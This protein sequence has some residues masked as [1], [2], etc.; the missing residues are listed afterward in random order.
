MN[1][2]TKHKNCLI[3]AVGKN[4]LH[5]L[6]KKGICNYDI[7]LIVY[8]ESLDNFRADADFICHIKGYKLKAIYK[9]LEWHPYFLDAYD[10]F[11]FPDD[12]I[13]MDVTTINSLFDT[14]HHYRL[15]IAQPSLTMS[16]PT[17]PHLLK[18]KY[19]KL[20]Y[21][22][23][24]EMMVPL[25]SKEALRAVLFTFNENETGWGTEV[26]W[27]LLIKATHQDIAVIHETSVV[28]TRPIQSGQKIHFQELATYLK[29][30]NLK[31][32]INLYQSIPLY[33][34]NV[35]CCSQEV[36][37]ELRDVLFSWIGCEKNTFHVDNIFNYICFLFLFG[38]I[39]QSKVYSDIACKL[40]EKERYNKMENL[41]IEIFFSKNSF[42]CILPFIKHL[43]NTLS[44]ETID[45]L[46]L[47]YY[48]KY[49]DCLT[50]KNFAALG[51]YSLQMGNYEFANHIAR[52]LHKCSIQ[53]ESFDDIAVIFDVLEVLHRCGITIRDNIM[54]LEQ[55]VNYI[56]LSHLEYAYFLFRIYKLTKEKFVLIRIQEQLKKMSYKL[57]CLQDALRLAEILNFNSL[58]VAAHD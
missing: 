44:F 52:I 21:T 2:I 41:L 1:Y 45:K 10:Y 13:K 53:P 54:E 25:F 14:M 35:F 40:L 15:K 33:K 30:Y 6:W 27:P 17:W 26:H 3:S 5:K 24:V 16:Y 57:T 12:D 36:F 43:Q 11:F 50:W 19:C 18:D 28:H 7:H 47:H 8:D 20:R 56:E 46:V 29:K 38:E 58:K 51:V 32:N 23:F 39:S 4:S 37:W 48:H 55:Y 49:K 42:L 9:Y 31:I 34:E 22:N